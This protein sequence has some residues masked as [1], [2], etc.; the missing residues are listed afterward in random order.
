MEKNTFEKL[1]TIKIEAWVI[2]LLVLILLPFLVFS[3]W[4]VWHKATGGNDSG[5]V[6]D[7]LQDLAKHTDPYFKLLFS[8]Q[9]IQ[10]IV[11]PQLMS[12]EEF[13]GFKVYDNAQV[14]SGSLLV[15][16]YSDENSVSSV[17]LYDISEQK[18]LH[19]WVPPVNELLNQTSFRNDQSKKF[20]FRSQHPLLLEDGSIVITS[21]E[22]PLLKIDSCGKLQWSADRHFHHTI[23]PSESGGFYVPIVSSEIKLP[24][25]L[26]NDAIAKVSATGEVLQEWS[27]YELLIRH[28]YADLLHGFGMMERDRIHLNDAE[29]IFQSDNFVQKG[30]LMLS[31][32]NLSMVLVYRP[33]T[34]EIVWLEIG[35]WLNQHDVDY[36]GD[37][38]FTIYGNDMIR[39]KDT[40]YSF[41]GFNTIWKYDQTTGKTSEYLSLKEHQINTITEGRHRV[42]DNGDIIIEETN[43]GLIHRVNKDGKLWSFVHSLKQGKIGAL[44]WSRYLTAEESEFTWLEGLHCN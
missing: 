2:L 37:G 38:I 42:L 40:S 3:T 30:D 39:N 17:Y 26:R 1:L 23:E 14:D 9:S 6:G 7:T 18:I 35:P 22:G 8:E 33:S 13:S 41:T 25:P 12:F 24:F 16:A 36:L 31:V 32:R 11:Q 4:A 28:G 15:S 19:E 20:N 34:D 44:H 27:I 5:K 43:A 10:E 21:G 29:V